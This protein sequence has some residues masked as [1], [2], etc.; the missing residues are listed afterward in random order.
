MKIFSLL[1]LFLL[2]FVGALA[3]LN[4]ETFTAPSPLSLGVA[5]I[6]VPLGLVMMTLLAVFTVLFLAFA[7]YLQGSAL[8]QARRHE[9]ALQTNRDLA[10]KAEA[11]RFSALQTQLEIELKNLHGAGSNHKVE[12][13][14]R[15]DALDEK[16][17]ALL[18]QSE[19]IFSAY[20]GELE[21]RLDKESQARVISLP[22]E[23][24]N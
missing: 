10:D 9:K 20:F 15:L 5:D 12:I 13:L 16:I 22:S 17:S 4:W 14:S 19:N 23:K 6:H 11:S 21:D 7:M 2:T 18:K 1:I 24:D 8:L 3:F